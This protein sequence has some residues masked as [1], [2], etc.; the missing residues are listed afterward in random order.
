VLN[1]EVLEV[2]EVPE[3]V[4]RQ[5]AEQELQEI[6]RREQAYRGNRP[7]VRVQGRTV[8]LVDDGLATG[9]TMRAAVMA[10]QRQHPAKVV[11]A[12]PVGARHTCEEL[13][14]QV[15]ELICLVTPEPFYSVGMWY[16]D[17]HQVDDEE[18]RA[19]LQELAEPPNRLN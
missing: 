16:R 13:Q 10:T 7:R 15:D 5:V 1:D 18:V 19:L 14:H 8:L 2:L 12:V 4:V 17:F 3:E 11:V 9:A 6:D